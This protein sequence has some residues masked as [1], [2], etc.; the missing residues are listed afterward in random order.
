MGSKYTPVKTEQTPGPGSYVAKGAIDSKKKNL[1]TSGF[2]SASRKAHDRN[3]SE[4]G[5]GGYDAKVDN[6]KYKSPSF[7]FGQAKGRNNEFDRTA[8]A[9]G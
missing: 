9:P 4:I 1:G 3:A 6:V 7:G 8:P 5:P 2:G